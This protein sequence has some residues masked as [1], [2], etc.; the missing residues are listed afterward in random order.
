M[1][2]SGPYIVYAALA[3]IVLCVVSA[4]GYVQSNVTARS[5][6]RTAIAKPLS[7]QQIQSRRQAPMGTVAIAATTTQ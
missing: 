5:A 3:L 2:N 4:V 7:E 6:A 1:K